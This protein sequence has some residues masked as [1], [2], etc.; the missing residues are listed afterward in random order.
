MVLFVLAAHN[1]VRYQGFR[2]DSSLYSAH[3][4]EKE[5]LFMEGAPVVVM[6]VDL[7]RFDEKA[8]TDPFMKYFNA[9]RLTVVYLFHTI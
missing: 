5:I 8:F 2:L 7:I 1:Y 3:P 6:G 4:T 9:K